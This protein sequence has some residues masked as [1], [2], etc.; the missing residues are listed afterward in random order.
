MFWKTEVV[1]SCHCGSRSLGG[2]G[3]LG[4]G[5]DE[6]FPDG[7]ARNAVFDG[8]A[9]R[10]W[11]YMDD[12]KMLARW[13]GALHGAMGELECTHVTPDSMEAYNDL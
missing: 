2:C 12:R 8:N 13:G 10:V 7:T 1:R 9:F 11:T 6:Q 4:V 5:L 3:P